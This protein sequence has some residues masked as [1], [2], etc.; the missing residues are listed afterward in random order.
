VKRSG[1][2]GLTRLRYG[3]PFCTNCRT[4]LREGDDV[5]W[6]PTATG[7]GKTVYCASCHRDRRRAW[8]LDQKLG[9]RSRR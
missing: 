2:P 9:E 1:P 8:H 5:A 3:S 7:T 6:W 4:V